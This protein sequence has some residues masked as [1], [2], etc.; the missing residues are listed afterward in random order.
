[1]K[2]P[3]TLTKKDPVLR[4]D[5]CI[6]GASSAGLSI[7]ATGALLGISVVLITSDAMGTDEPDLAAAALIAS[8][9]RAHA[10][11]SGVAFGIGRNRN[12]PDIDYPA[13]RRRMREV[14]ASQN[15]MVSFDRY[16]A[17]GVRVVESAAH[18]TDA[19][20]VAAGNLVIKARRF[21]I[22]T[23]S[24]PAIPAIPGLEEIAY[25]T[26]ET[27]FDL[28]EM[29]SRLVVV[30][31]GATGIAMA[32]AFR[33]L[34]A[35]V[36]LI[37]SQDRLLA[38]EDP[39]LTAIVERCLREEGIAVQL[40]SEINRFE[41]RPDGGIAAVLAEGGGAVVEGSH[42]LIAGGRMHAIESLGLEA[43]KIR[44]S[45]S[46]IL[47]NRRMRS[48]N[49]RGLRRG[50]RQ[51]RIAPRRGLFTR[52]DAASQRRL[53]QRGPRAAGALRS[54]ARPADRPFRS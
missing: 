14:I 39:E 34:G 29:P 33:R 38:E 13:V 8:A 51:R 41:T 46:G 32:Q 2:K 21:M 47:V 36:T 45:A 20:T 54:A 23:G 5:L 31:G 3:T 49:S 42:L 17:M 30:G 6:I 43:G 4:P 44:A 37:A 11:R 53:S 18:F 22:A 1:M 24:R 15:S 25:L 10:V 28:A 19:E 40:G 50:P 35:E 27:I 16:R 12:E 7:A 48:S 26:D 9:N 52:G